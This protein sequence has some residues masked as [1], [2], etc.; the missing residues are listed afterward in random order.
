MNLMSRG[1]KIEAD[2][3]FSIESNMYQIEEACKI[4]SASHYFP[5]LLR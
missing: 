1:V 4:D 3:L 2:E 5:G